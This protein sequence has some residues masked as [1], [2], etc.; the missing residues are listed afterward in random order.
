MKIL[1][2][3]TSLVLCLFIL[4]LPLVS[5]HG[6]I[7]YE[8]APQYAPAYEVAQGVHHKAGP[9]RRYA[10]PV[11][12]QERCAQYAAFR[13]PGEGVYVIQAEGEYG[14]T[15]EVQQALA[16]G[17]AEGQGGDAGRLAGHPGRM[18][19]RRAA[20]K[21]GGALSSLHRPALAGISNGC[22]FPMPPQD[23]GGLGRPFVR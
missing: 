14:R 6:G 4:C 21:R 8:V 9:R 11:L 10:Q 19:Q 20:V 15:E 7:E 2:K 5:C 3:I 18:R 23:A 17:K 12:E 22:R 13:D 1:F 16:P